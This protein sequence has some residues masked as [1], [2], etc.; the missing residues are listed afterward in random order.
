MQYVLALL[1]L[2]LFTITL[3][4]LLVL[5]LSVN[6]LKTYW[7]NQN[8]KQPVQ[9]E[10]IYVVLGDSTAQGVGATYPI[11]S[12]PS[13]IAK[14]LQKQTARPVRVIN[15][16][17][18]GAN[19]KDVFTQQIPQM[20]RIGPPHIVTVCIGANNVKNF[21][22]EQF[23]SEMKSIVMAL[24]R[25]SYV[26]NVVSFT[27]LHSAKDWKAVQAGDLVRRCV[28]TTNHHFVDLHTETASNKSL[29]RHFAADMFHP[30]A[31]AYKKW[32]IAFEKAMAER[33][34][35]LIQLKK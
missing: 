6:H 24:P 13:L 1:V 29:L 21:H 14:W 33:I 5:R 15:L 27:G 7:L 31:R 34:P 18:T 8:Q 3:V 2:I 20:Y 32:A 9:N 23:E 16:S 22:A 25:E 28:S 26:A 11:F 4:R 10:L 17:V 12:Y 19:A 35:E 30:N